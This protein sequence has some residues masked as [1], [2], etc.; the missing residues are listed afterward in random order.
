MPRVGKRMDRVRHL[1]R[2]ARELAAL[3]EPPRP[4]ATVSNVV[5]QFPDAQVKLMAFLAGEI[6]RKDCRQCVR[7]DL[8]HECCPEEPL[9]RW[10]P[11][12]TWVASEHPAAF[13]M[14]NVEALCTEMMSIAEDHVATL[15][16]G[17]RRFMAV[18]HQLLGER[19]TC[20]FR[21]K[22]KVSPELPEFTAPY[23]GIDLT[24]AQISTIGLV[25][26]R[27]AYRQLRDRQSERIHKAIAEL[28]V[29]GKKL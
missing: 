22:F 18:A 20:S 16:H 7:V 25:D 15:D 24:D 8:R 3:A 27:V 17:S 12:R 2:T 28:K 19:Q 14:S 29:R 13:V 26:L 5:D 11:I 10:K 6:G 1:R 4:V 9:N 21:I 23:P